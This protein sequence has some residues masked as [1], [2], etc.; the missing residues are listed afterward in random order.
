MNMEKF[1]FDEKAAHRPCNFLERYCTHVE[2]ELMGN[3]I[4]LMSYQREWISEVFGTKRYS[5]GLRRYR[6]VY[7]EIPK[8][9]AKSTTLAGLGLFLTGYD[10]EP[11]A[12]VFVCAGDKFQARIIF[13]IAK[14]MVEQNEA[15]KK[16]FVV[17][18]DAIHHRATNSQFHVT[19]AD[20]PTKHGFNVSAVIF[21]ELHVQKNRELWDTFS[22]GVAARRQPLVFALTTAGYK[23]TFA[24]EVHLAAKN[25]LLGMVESEYWFVKMYGI[26]EERAISEYDN[27]RLWEE[28]NPG[29][30]VTVNP[31]YFKMQMEE[32]KK[33]PSALTAFLR[34]HLNVWTGTS[35]TWDILPHWRKCNRRAIIEEEFVGRTCFGGMDL[36]RVGDT[37]ALV[38][39]F[40]NAD[41]TADVLCRVWIP[42]ETLD[43]RAKDESTLWRQ[44][45]DEGLVRVTPGNVIDQD[46]I[47]ADVLEDCR[48]FVVW[49][50]D[51]THDPSE[52][53]AGL[54]CDPYAAWQIVPKMQAAGVPAG[55][56]AQNAR[57]LCPAFSWLEKAITAGEI[58]HGGNR[59]LAWQ[60]SCVE[61]VTMQHDNRMPS[62]KDSKAR[63]DLISALMNAV[64]A[65][66]PT[67]IEETGFVSIYE[68]AELWKE[69]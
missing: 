38:W 56:F 44:W 54:N 58:N 57:N 48:K 69:I 24:H 68:N 60:A 45:V 62:K 20:A 50:D 15:L 21:D 25:I 26:E 59:V 39:L 7:I 23:E 6:Y 61:I 64:A 17:Y 2:G 37:S 4:A 66:L 10:G 43:Q 16:A 53:R 13:N 32:I 36:A 3:P 46:V 65:Y 55:L 11:G 1:Y 18:S 42:E 35:K 29:Y 49:Q 27:P 5:D 52:K 30:G 63:I 67:T 14:K 40:P 51:L 19:S 8:K 34:L 28:A 22:K 12:Q 41:G 9:N 31:D 33:T 47:L